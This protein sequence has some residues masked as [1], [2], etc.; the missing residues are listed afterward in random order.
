MTAPFKRIIIVAIVLIAIAGIACAVVIFGN[1]AAGAG[2]P[3]AD[4]KNGAVNT[5]LDLSGM[6]SRIDSELR[7][8]AGKLAEENGISQAVVDNVI[9]S[10]AIEDWKVVSLPDSATTTGSY[11]V[12]T[13]SMSARITTYDDP[14]FVTVEAYGH[15]LPM[16]VPQ[17]ARG[18]VTLLGYLEGA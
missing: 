13:D 6:K 7:A 2:N 14:S 10:L 5:V 17:S 3:L 15:P 8:K 16:D 9:D 11:D 12:N 18:D 1:S 4:A